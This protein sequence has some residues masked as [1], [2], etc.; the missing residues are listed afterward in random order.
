MKVDAIKCPGCNDIIYSRSRHDCRS[1]SCGKTFI[2]GG[3]D[4]TRIGSKFRILLEIKH[5]KINVNATKSEM[6]NDWNLF[7]NKY[8]LIKG[9]K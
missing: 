4:Y 5:I 7:G 9:T 8:G 2:D 1:C 3:F 6:Y